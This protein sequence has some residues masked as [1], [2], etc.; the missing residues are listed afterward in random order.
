M[1]LAIVI[2]HN[3]ERQGA[4]RADTGETEFVW[5]SRLAKQIEDQAGE[6]GIEVRRFFRTPG[7]EYKAELARTYAQV[8]AWGADASI[9]LHFNGAASPNA[10]G[11][12]VLSSG[13][14]LSLMLAEEVQREMVGALGLRDRGVKT[15]AASERGGGSLFSGAAPAILVEPFFGSSAKD[16]AATDE[17]HEQSALADAILRGAAVAFERFPRSDLSQSRTIKAAQT[18]RKAA[19]TASV[20][21]VA[22][23][24]GAAA[25]GAREQL[26]AIPAVGPLA[27]W[28]PMIT[29]GLV[30]VAFVATVI[31][32]RETDK[33]EAARYDDHD[34]AVLAR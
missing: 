29:V 1:K 34:R 7:G 14:A 17:P 22:A 16:Q 5:N 20:S 21:Q 27:E 23:A 10:T 24:C 28:L 3:S 4:V 9:E 15:R 30:L 32:R 11:T 33:I 31:S 2:G 8:D 18:Q 25:N 13:T 6:Y 19:Q 12:E 26:E